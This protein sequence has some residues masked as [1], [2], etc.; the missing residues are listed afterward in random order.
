MLY[1]KEM[2]LRV[3]KYRDKRDLLNALLEDDKFYTLDEVDS[4][5]ENYYA[6]EIS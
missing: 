6:K 2:L 3:S 1:S 5:I 4:L